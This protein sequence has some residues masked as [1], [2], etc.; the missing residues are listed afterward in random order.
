MDFGLS[1]QVYGTAKNDI[2]KVEPSSLGFILNVIRQKLGRFDHNILYKEI[3]YFVNC[4]R[5][6]M[7]PAPSAEE[8]AI[9]LKVIS[10]L[11]ENST[12]LT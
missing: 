8:G 12:E 10:M 3:E 6:D 4:L 2:V 11:Y 1:V 7:P 5:A 9:D